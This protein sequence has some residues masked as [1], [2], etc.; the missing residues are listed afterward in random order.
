MGTGTI[1]ESYSPILCRAKQLLTDLPNVEQPELYRLTWKT[2]TTYPQLLEF[3]ALTA[4][5]TT[6]NPLNTAR[7]RN[8]VSPA[9]RLQFDTTFVGDY[10]FSIDIS[11]HN[12][13]GAGER[14]PD[15]SI[16]TSVHATLV[17]KQLFSSFE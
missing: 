14:T 13:P 6:Y 17:P 3:R 1:V 7:A 10:L 8:S 9:S 15:L 4:H 11:L 12:V 16:S 2:S 5:K